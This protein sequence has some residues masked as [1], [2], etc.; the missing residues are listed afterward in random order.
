MDDSQTEMF[1]GRS[2]QSRLTESQEVN[3]PEQHVT[4]TLD[5]R[6][7]SVVKGKGESTFSSVVHWTVRPKVVNL[8]RKTASILLQVMVVE[9]A[10]SGI[11]F[12]GY[13]ASEFLVSFLLGGRSDPLEVRDEKERKALLLG[14]L[15]LASVRGEWLTLSERIKLPPAVGQEI[16]DCPWL[17]NAR[18]WNS[19]KQY[20]NPRTLLE[21]LTVPMTTYDERDSATTRY[22]GYT[23]G[24]GNGGH[25]SRVKKTPYDSELDGESTD[26]EPPG[27]NLLEI[28]RYNHLLLLIEKEKIERLNS[29]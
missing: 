19:W 27:L 16:L 13:L 10:S 9:F 8:E 24:Y 21:V 3:L 1:G 11:D 5:L 20:H 15:I 17:P 18:T 6:G 4:P 26:R 22:S 14:T 23:K 28:D 29:K 12:T 2:E 7:F 25:I